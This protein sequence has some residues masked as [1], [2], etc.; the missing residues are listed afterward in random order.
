MGFGELLVPIVW[1][2]RSDTGGSSLLQIDEMGD[3]SG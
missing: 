1:E 3:V 2:A